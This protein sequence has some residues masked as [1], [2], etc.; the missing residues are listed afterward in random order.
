MKPDRGSK[1]F[2][3]ALS[4]EMGGKLLM[5]GDGLVPADLLI[6]ARMHQQRRIKGLLSNGLAEPLEPVQ[7]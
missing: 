1:G 3:F 7:P 5:A 2:L 4:R 6:A